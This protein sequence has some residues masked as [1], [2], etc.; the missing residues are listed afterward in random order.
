MYKLIILGLALSAQL[1]ALTPKE[2]LQRLTE[3]NERFTSD[4]STH[5]DRTAERRQETAELQEPFATILGCSD[6]RVAP[7]IIF[8]QGIGDLFIVRVAGNVSGPIE[9]DSIEYSVVYLHSS[10]IVVLG[11][12]NCGAVKAVLHGITKDIESVAELIQPAVKKTK[13]QTKHRLESA[14]Q[15]NAQM[16]AEKLRKSPVLS[17]Y[18]KEKKL[19]IVAGYYDFH[20][21]KVRILPE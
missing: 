14:I 10:L 3:G 2:A 17:R 13:D 16:V 4:A 11:H 7:E 8:D 9:L 6:S 20:D 19:D 5:P 12:E 1:C 21:G 15:L 18:I